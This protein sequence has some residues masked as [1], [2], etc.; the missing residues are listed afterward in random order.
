MFESIEALEKEVQDFKDNI[1][2]SSELV[3]TIEQ[4]TV[5]TK[6]QQEKLEANAELYNNMSDAINT[7]FAILASGVGVAIILIIVALFVK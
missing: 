3:R 5:V 2:A 7:K 6:A 4:L 1:L